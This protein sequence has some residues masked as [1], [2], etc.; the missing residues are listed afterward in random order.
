VQLS[1]DLGGAATSVTVLTIG[2]STAALVNAAEITANAATDANTPDA[3]VKRDSS[4]DFSAGTITADLIG[5]VTDFSGPLVGD[6]TGTQ[7]A[8]VVETVGGSTAAE[9]YAGTVAANTATA[10]NTPSAIVKRDASGDLAAGTVTADLTGNV[11]GDLTGNVTGN[12]TGNATGNAGTVTNGVYTSRQVIAGSGLTGGGALTSDVTL[13]LTTPVGVVDGGMGTDLSGSAVVGDLLVADSASTFAR[14]AKG[15]EFQVLTGGVASPTW[16]ALTLSEASAVTGVLPIANGGTGQTAKADAFDALSPF[17]ALGDLLYGGASGTGTALAGNTTTDMQFLTQTGDGANSAAPAW[18]TLVAADV[19]DLDAAKITTGSFS[20]VVGGTGS[21]LSATGPG[22]LQQINLGDSVTV[23]L[24]SAGDYPVMVGDGGAGG[25]QGAVP[26]PGAGDTAA[27]KYLTAAGTWAVPASQPPNS[28]DLTATYITQVPD[29]ALINSQAL[30]DLGYG[31]ILKVEETTGIISIATTGTDY[32]PG[33]HNH[34]ASELI[35]GQLILAQGGTG[36]DLGSTGGTGQFVKQLGVGD[37]M[38]VGAITPAELPA[39]TVS[40]PGIVQLTGNLGGTY[41]APTVITVGGSTAANIHGAELIANTATNS[42][43]AS[44]VVRRDAI[45]NFSAGT[46]TASLAG[47]ATTATNGVNSASGTAPLTLSLV[48]GVLTNSLAVTPTNSGGAVAL[49][50]STPGTAQ[51]GNLNISGTITAGGFVGNTWK[52]TA[53]PGSGNY[54]GEMMTGQTAGE[55]LSQK[56]VAY[57][58]ADAKWYKAKSDAAA[59]SGPVKLGICPA[60]IGS[61]S[62]GVILTRGILEVSGWSLT[63]GSLYFV[64]YTTAGNI[65]PVAT[66]NP[67]AGQQIRAVGHALSLTAFEFEPSVDYGEK[68][69]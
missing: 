1:G 21:D 35:S 34:D 22:F 10:L 67:S 27:G 63:V 26:A 14:L 41:T 53:S 6:V 44:S 16:G 37:P 40:E 28:G 19:P 52:V 18:H 8:T 58:A 60:G 29:A 69:P 43:V 9:V 66:F 30:S 12:L 25:T 56:D 65:L 45:G 50:S 36:A 23:A 51:T 20:L 68:S 32:A 2:G 13:S 38:T 54:W 55:A 7:S 46:I 57:L 39:A 5:S 31:G 47:N 17:A 3:I 64:D 61:G 59:T 49:Q 33:V 42:N 48:A 4:G 15:T 62:T 24:L 11:V